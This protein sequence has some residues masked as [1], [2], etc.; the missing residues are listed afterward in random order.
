MTTSYVVTFLSGFLATLF[1]HS[2]MASWIH[3]YMTRLLHGYTREIA[4]RLA[5][6]ILV[7]I[8]LNCEIHPFYKVYILL[9]KLLRFMHANYCNYELNSENSA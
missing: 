5:T 3:S 7:C 8:V 1:P 9:F 6:Y 4:T 2:F